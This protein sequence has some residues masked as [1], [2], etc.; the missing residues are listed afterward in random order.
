MS[1]ATKNIDSLIAQQEQILLGL[2][3]EA[4]ALDTDA[5]TIENEK[6]TKSLAAQ[7]EKNQELEKSETELKNA[8]QSTK[9]A[10]FSKMADEKL[11][12]FSRV[13]QRIDSAYYTA[14]NS[15]VSRLADYERN[16]RQSIAA[17]QKAIEDYGR[18]EFTEISEKLSALSRELDEKRRAVDEYRRTQFNA[19]REHNN[20]IGESLRTEPLTE[21]EKRAAARQKSLEAFIGLNVLSKLGILLL[22][23]GIILLGRFAYTHMS[24][25]FKGV[26]I[27]ALGGVLIGGGELF[28]KKEKTVFSTALISGGVAVLYAATATSLFAL[29]LFDEQAA[30][31]VCIIVTAIAILISNQIKSWIVCAFATVGGYLPLVAAFMISFGGAAA[32]K[33]YLPAAASYFTFLAVVVFILTNNKKWQVAQ[34]IGYAFQILAVGGITACAWSLHNLN[35]YENVLPLA[36]AFAV[37]SYIVYLAMPAVKIFRKQELE[38]SDL[39]LLGL[40]T[41]SGAISVAVTLYNNFGSGVKGNRAVGFAFVVFAAIYA[42]LSVLSTKKKSN[43]GKIASAV[44]Y[45]SALIFSMLI[46]PFL[47]GWKYAALAWAAEGAILAVISIRKELRVPE[48]AGLGCMILAFVPYF[49]AEVG[50]DPNTAYPPIAIITLCIILVSFWAYTVTGLSSDRKNKILY[51][52]FEIASAIGTFSYLIYL[53]NAFMASPKITYNSDFTDDVFIAVIGLITAISVRL[54]VLKNKVSIGFSDVAGLLLSLY[55]L[56]AVDIIV[57]YDE[58]YSYYSSGAPI[59]S[60]VIFNLVLLVVINIAV[61]LFFSKVVSSIINELKLPVWIY[62]A[63]ISVLALAMI[64]AILMAQFEVKFS[65]V[66]ISGIYIAAACVLLAVGF[67]KR[68]SVVR[69]GGLIMILVAFAKLLFVDARGLESSAFKIAAYFIYGAILIGISYLYQRFSKKL[70]KFSEQ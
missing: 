14:D 61:A 15:T 68:F 49:A 26:L 42:L 6:L 11:T 1:K 39:V 29:K 25:I 17:T 34:Y 45:T 30:F 67:A 63:S 51:Y 64:T 48:F 2:K 59:K 3:Q 33:T 65:S 20:K 4:K 12:A 53:Y 46:V 50:Y 57:C 9:N 38:A 35:G 31:I 58:A 8:L 27:Y 21:A 5:V 62:T 19:A 23:V 10:L 24:D 52:I 56:I 28:H 16:C 40:N 13:Q 22:I 7:I 70:D 47:F 60:G 54:G 32:S 69:L 18:G 36:V 55:T 44:L 37:A 43:S 66:I 41:V